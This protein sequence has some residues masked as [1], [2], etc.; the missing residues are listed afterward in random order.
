MISV[1]GRPRL[2]DGLACPRPVSADSRRCPHDHRPDGWHPP[3]TGPVPT[4]ADLETLAGAAAPGERLR[5]H[6]DDLGQAVQLAAQALGVLAAFVEKDFWVTEA[7]RSLAQPLPDDRGYVIL[8]GGTS[9]LKLGLTERMS[10]DVDALLVATGGRDRRDTTL[11]MLHARVADDLCV[12]RPELIMASAGVKRFVEYPYPRAYDHGSL[13]PY[14]YVELGTRGGPEPNMVYGFRSFLARHLIENQGISEDDFVELRPVW[15]SVLSP[16]RTAIEKLASLHDASC[17]LEPDGAAKLANCVRHLYDI[18]ALL[19]DE[20]TRADLAGMEIAEVSADVDQHSQRNDWTF[21]PRP[22]R[23]YAAS[24]AFDEPA[25]S[26]LRAAWPALEPLVYGP[27]AT[28]DDCV[29]RIAEHAG[30]F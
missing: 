7:I 20:V 11:K 19:G 17:R 16:C 10:E 9:L 25:L 3:F 4:L 27:L 21:T 1:C 2:T 24:P 28:A 26:V 18:W 8:K 5:D 30:L 15:V 12:E 14:V 13:K 23:G 22:E 29:G 6:P